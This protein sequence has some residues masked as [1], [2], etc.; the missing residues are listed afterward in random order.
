M[1]R[2]AIIVS[3]DEELVGILSRGLAGAGVCSAPTALG[4]YPDINE[5]R[6]AMDKVSAVTPLAA[7]V[8]RDRVG[9]LTSENA[10]RITMM[11]MLARTEKKRITYGAGIERLCELI[12][13]AADVL[14]AFPNSPSERR[15]RIDWPN[16]IPVSEHDML[17]NAQLKRDL[18]VSQAQVLA[19]LGYDECP[20]E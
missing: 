11:G 7:G 20:A 9:N 15:V 17:R 13:H 6:E 18:G 12:L 8:L 10:L 4:Y 3:P 16:P 2:H 1:T 14:G 19:E 5:I